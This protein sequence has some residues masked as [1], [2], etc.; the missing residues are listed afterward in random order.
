MSRSVTV[1]W[2]DW[3]DEDTSLCQ[4]MW[5]DL[6]SGIRLQVVHVTEW[7]PVVEKS[8]ELA[9]SNERDTLLFCGHGTEHG[10]LVPH[11]YGEYVLHEYNTHLIQAETV[12][13]ITCYGAEFAE[14]VGLHGLF[15][16][17]F[18]SNIDEA[19]TIGIQNTSTDEIHE[20]NRAFL[21]E[22]SRFISGETSMEACLEQLQRLGWRDGVSAFN[23]EGMRIL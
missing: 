18:I 20:S 12:I 4:L 13:G 7:N 10:L 9:V 23:A 19:V 5:R 6:P 17:M 1:I 8:V 11:S 15:S 2:C 16:S 3:G 21:I 14:S 22:I